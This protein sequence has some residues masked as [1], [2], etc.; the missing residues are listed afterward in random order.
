MRIAIIVFFMA[1]QFELMH[2]VLAN[3]TRANY[4]TIIRLT[5]AAINL[6]VIGGWLLR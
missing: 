4:A 3:D 1:A 5:L 6:L 2:F